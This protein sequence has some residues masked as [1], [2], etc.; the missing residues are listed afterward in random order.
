MEFQ[1]QMHLKIKT[2]NPLIC[3]NNNFMNNEKG[4]QCAILLEITEFQNTHV[5]LVFSFDR[6]LKQRESRKVYI[7]TIKKHERLNQNGRT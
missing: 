7:P 5:F 3:V 2:V 4:S 6:Y 1:V